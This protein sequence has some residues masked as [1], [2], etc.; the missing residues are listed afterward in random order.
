MKIIKNK[1]I[2]ILILFLTI[3]WYGAIFIPPI[4]YKSDFISKKTGG[5]VI[6]FFSNVCHQQEQRSFKI[7]GVQLAVCS[8]CTGLYTGFFAGVI[9]YPFLS[10]KFKFKKLL[11][12]GAVLLFLE[13]IFSHL[14]MFNSSNT[15]RFLTGLLPGF[16]VANIFISAAYEITKNKR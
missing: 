3:I 5:A 12:A 9:F 14:Y 6:C 13:F 4:A 11:I 16:V 8:R 15:I 2:F 1:K 7:H 10:G